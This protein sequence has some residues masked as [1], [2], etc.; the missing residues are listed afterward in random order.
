M[1]DAWSSFKDLA[2]SVDRRWVLGGGAALA[3]LGT[4]ALI[5]PAKEG[6]VHSDYFLSLSE[7][8]KS[9]GLM[10]PTLV[11]DRTAFHANI[12]T[13]TSSLADH[14][15]Y[16]IVAKSVPSLPL[17]QQVMAR[18]NTNRLMI[19]HQPFLNLVAAEV[20]D[21]DIL[22]GKPMP[23]DAAARFYKHA[24]PGGVDPARQVQWLID[25]PERLAQY[26]ALA[27]GQD[28][29]MRI[30]LEINVGLQRGGLSDPSSLKPV[31]ETID[32]DPNL[33]FAG[34]MGYDP[35]VAAVPDLMGW[36]G[37]SLASSISTYEAFLAEAARHYG[38]AWRPEALTL[39]TA[40]SP[41][42]QF[43]KAS[44]HANEVA[45][46][47]AL[48]KPTSFDIPTLE[49]HQPASFIATPVL[50]AMER[51][52]I[53]G[54]EALTGITRLWNRNRARAWFIYGGYWKANPVSPPGLS[55][56]PMFRSTNQE[57]LNGSD[58]IDLQPDDLVFLRPTQS[59]FVFLQ[60]GDIA[61]YEDGALIDQWPVF[62][63]GA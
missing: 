48:V 63:Q 44:T 42:Y 18:A 3:A 31:L 33:T 24:Q 59:E 21:A 2:S 53:P 35:H 19:F 38:D 8:L 6:G 7:A 17:L 25:T 62:T 50:K 26:Q 27:R 57:M 52:D 12:D 28:L 20:P 51:A 56:N 54:L 60:F 46:G 9:E 10:R 32:A 13:V 39:N 11:I 23:V 36:Q 61:V 49:N 58:R 15:H 41:T 5:R 43:H 16:R 30:N 4:A 55:P 22:L 47:S 1:D 34:F 45:V 40:G 14:M 29:Q 37:R